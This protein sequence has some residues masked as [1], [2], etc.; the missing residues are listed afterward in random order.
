M[1][2]ILFNGKLAQAYDKWFETKRGSLADWFEKELVLRIG[3]LKPGEIMLDI[4][5]GTGHH[6]QFFKAKGIKVIGIDISIHMLRIAQKKLGKPNILCLGRAEDLPF[7]EKSFDSVLLITTLEFLED[8]LKALQETVRVSRDKII[9]GVLNR[10]SLTGIGRRI[11]GLFHPTIYKKAKF[12]SIWELIHLLVRVSKEFWIDWGSVLTLP[13]S[14]QDK[15]RYIEGILSFKKNPFG[16][17]L[18]VRASKKCIGKEKKALS[19][20][21]V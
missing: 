19:P 10:Y 12:Y 21:K 2:K 11:S 16:A 4:G 20:R 5:C 8:P 7:K 18:V 9:L 3:K 6:I 14:F 1:E 13:L 17:F 15:F